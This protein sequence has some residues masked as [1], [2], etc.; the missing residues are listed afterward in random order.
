M[1]THENGLIPLPSNLKDVSSAT[2]KRPPLDG[3]MSLTQIFDW[4]AQNSPNHHLFIYNDKDGRVQSISWRE[5]VAAIY[6][7]ARL[8]HSQTANICLGRHG[9]PVIAIVSSTDTI[10]YCT[11]IMSILRANCIAFPI[12][13][14]NSPA[15]VAHLFEQV[16]VDHVYVGEPATHDLIKEALAILK[17]QSSPRSAPSFSQMFVFEDLFLPA[18]EDAL[19][20]IPGELPHT[21]SNHD[22][23][24]YL[25]SSGSLAFPKAMPMTD[26]KLVQVGQ[27]PWSGE[28]EL[29]DKVLALHATPMFHGMGISQLAWTACAGVVLAVFEPKFPAT[30]PTPENLF[31]ASRATSSDV[32]IAVP[33]FIEAWAR[34]PEYVE[35]LAGCSGVVYGGGTLNKEVGD[36][37]TS[38][39]VPIF[40]L[41]G[42]TEVGTLSMTLPAKTRDNYDWHYL[43][44]SGLFREHWKSHGDDLYELVIVDSPQCT[45]SVFNTEVDGVRAYATSDLFTRHPTKSGYWKMYGRADDQIIHSTGEKTNPVPLESLLGQDPHL[46]GAVL[47]GQGR[48]NAGVLVEPKP[49]LRFD[50][51]D[52]AKLAEFRN[53]IWPTVEQMN[54][55][56]PRHSRVFKEMI[57]VSSPQKPFSY[58]PKNTPK[59]QAI[60]RDYAE[61]IAGL[62]DA[63]SETTQIN[64]P[65]PTSWDIGTTK[66][67]VRVVIATIL[68]HSVRDDDDLFQYG[69]DSLQA[70]WIRNGILRGLRES[71]DLDTRILASNFV[72]DHP[73]INRLSSFVLSLAVS[74]MEPGN[75]DNTSVKVRVMNDLVAQYS[76][77]LACPEKHDGP[78]SSEKIVLLTGSTGSLGSHILSDLIQNSE[79]RHV[80]ALIRSE[81]AP[82]VSQRQRT[83]FKRRGLD[84]TMIANDK[85]TLLAVDLADS[86]LGLGEELFISVQG[87]ITH[88][89]DVAWRVDFNLNVVSF[90]RNLKS[91]RNLIDL[92]LRRNAHYTFAS[93]VAVCRNAPS[94]HEELV[95]AESA[96]GNG[97]SESKWVAEQIIA[98]ASDS[99]LRASIVRVGQLSGGRNGSWSTKEWLPSLVQASNVLKKVPDDNR[100]ASW[101]PLHVASKTFVDLIDS[102]A[103]PGVPEVFHLVH[104]NPI[105]WTTLA[106]PLSKMLDASVV[107]Y[108]EW[109]QA[110]EE[111]ARSP[112]ASSLK[113]NAFTLLDFFRI[114]STQDDRRET[115][116]FGMP[117]L[118]MERTPPQSKSLTYHKSRTLGEEDVH[119]WVNYWQNEGIL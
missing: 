64:V 41:Y 44:F 9:V 100:I 80:Y 59:R 16:G 36:Y 34:R 98:C 68:T 88:I 70:T 49:P 89:I 60:L 35:W 47:F 50:P 39:G 116:A 18:H 86:H 12:S 76:K 91:V 51:V 11:T 22:V 31:E 77:D 110:L 104:P 119:R 10:T 54:A 108:A 38:Q 2:F 8:I 63:V 3:S 101:I 56:A 55:H 14:R 84:P 62:Y 115:E 24:M 96:L 46:T 29:T 45:P 102:Q 72:Y 78:K 43:R 112:S 42:M 66:S 82:D 109:H 92:A 71:A 25:H 15:A 13:P 65:A 52:Q 74:G 57:L 95:A 19:I 106:Q 105:S 99:G 33:S 7:G 20:T 30:F 40:N 93:T 32:I 79:I 53:K 107:S 17:N 5:G 97:Y 6:N 67:F 85:V 81:G 4:Q 117:L 103:T 90:Q 118:V 21:L 37:M 27:M 114:I 69:C 23:I 87:T 113:L 1:Q 26:R 61:E 73:T 111:L 28:Q 75:T 83:S 94:G 58:T 48:F